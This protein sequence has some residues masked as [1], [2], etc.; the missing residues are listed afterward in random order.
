MWLGPQTRGQNHPSALRYP[1]ACGSA[2]PSLD[3]FANF[4]CCLS[5][6]AHPPSTSLIHPIRTCYVLKTW[7]MS[8]LHSTAQL[9]I[10]FANRGGGLCYHQADPPLWHLA[11]F[12]MLAQVWGHPYKQVDTCSPILGQ[13][14]TLSVGAPL[15]SLV[16]PDCWL[17]ALVVT[18]RFYATTQLVHLRAPTTRP[19]LIS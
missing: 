17:G 13:F 15:S 11:I 3:P 16:D 5:P 18:R 10:W 9:C 7:M 2:A 4:C 1:P 6:W 8:S 14:L 12:C 19:Q